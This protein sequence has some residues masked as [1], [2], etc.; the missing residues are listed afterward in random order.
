[1][2]TAP[3]YYTNTFT[4]NSGCDSLLVLNLKETYCADLALDMQLQEG[5]D[6]IVD[7]GDTIEFIIAITNEGTVPLYSIQVN[8]NFPEGIIFLESE[9]PDWVLARSASRIIS[10]PLQPGAVF[11]QTLT[12]R[13][14]SNPLQ[15]E[16][17]PVFSEITR[18]YFED[19]TLVADADSPSVID[20]RSTTTQDILEDDESVVRL[21]LFTCKEVPV[22]VG[23]DISIC[24]GESLSLFAFGGENH[25]WEPA[26]YL[27]QTT[28]SSPT[29]TVSYTHLTL[30]TK[31]I[32]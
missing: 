28:T 20:N 32:V 13:L 10:G 1:M 14:D 16:Q 6:S 30:P 9:N 3:G 22:Y 19:N 27:D 21:R 2:L 12:L 15:R 8:S 17:F 24:Q 23:E 7:I 29:T 11:Y 31:R 26:T 18:A 5:Q 25:R 4:S